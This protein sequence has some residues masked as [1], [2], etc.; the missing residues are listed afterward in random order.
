MGC[1]Y[2]CARSRCRL[3]ASGHTAAASSPCESRR[4]PVSQPHWGVSCPL[5]QPGALVKNKC[6]PRAGL[7]S[8][9][10]RDARLVCEQRPG[11]EDGG[12]GGRQ[13]QRGLLRAQ[14]STPVRFLGVKPGCSL[15]GLRQLHQEP[16][17]VDGWLPE[18]GKALWVTRSPL[19]VA[20]RGK[21]RG[22]W[23][24]RRGSWRFT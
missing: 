13:F 21:V 9:N 20:P 11:G 16:S 4:R 7:W 17:P 10:R 19:R 23:R 3:P 1:L 5:R 22:C 2:V 15:S 14:C 6:P 8:C 12:A 24:L 18:G